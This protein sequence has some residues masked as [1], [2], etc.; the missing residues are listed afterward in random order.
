[1]IPWKEGEEP[2]WLNKMLEEQG[3]ASLC[4]LSLSLYLFWACFIPS[5]ISFFFFSFFSL[6]VNCDS[7]PAVQ[8]HELDLEKHGLK[9][10][11]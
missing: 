4:S 5:F 2:D 11:L 8:V 6:Y 7:E 3:Y 9:Y 10:V 1:V